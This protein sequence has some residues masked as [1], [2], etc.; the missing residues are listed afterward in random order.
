LTLI[1]AVSVWATLLVTITAAVP[2]VFMVRTVL[3]SPTLLILALIAIG[4]P[5]AL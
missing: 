1:A 3:A 4:T 5:A 2:R